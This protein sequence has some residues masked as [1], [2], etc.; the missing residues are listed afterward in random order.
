[1]LEKAFFM[2]CQQ[3]GAVM[4]LKSGILK[5]IWKLKGH[6]QG[7]WMGFMVGGSEAA[8]SISMSFPM[9]WADN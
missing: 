8:M 4:T 6:G 5:A 7:W 9:G 3:L 2:F 1:M